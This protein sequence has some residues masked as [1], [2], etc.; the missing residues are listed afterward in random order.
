MVSRTHRKGQDT[1]LPVLY[2]KF[3]DDGSVRNIKCLHFN[4]VNDVLRSQIYE[5]GA[6]AFLT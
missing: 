6:S 2:P 3:R 1:A 4:A 5:V